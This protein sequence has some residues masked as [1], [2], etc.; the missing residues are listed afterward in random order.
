MAAKKTVTNAPKQRTQRSSRA[1]KSKSVT[2]SP[3]QITIQYSN[4]HDLLDKL[5]AV[6]QSVSRLHSHRLLAEAAGSKITGSTIDYISTAD[7]PDVLGPER[8]YAIVTTC[9]GE[10]DLTKKLGDIP[11]LDPVI[12]QSCVQSGVIAAGYKPGNVPASPGTML[13]EVLQAIQGCTK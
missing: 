5:F 10:T 2:I 11:G 13:W 1:K 6:T 3:K 9:A 4:S 7:I 12:F 8:A